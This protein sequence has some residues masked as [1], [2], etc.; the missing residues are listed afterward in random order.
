MR[1]SQRVAFLGLGLMGAPMARRLLDA[2][3]ELV[4]WNRS[5]EKCDAL[6][7]VG[8]RPA[9]TPAQA[10]A[11]A[12]FVCT[13]LLDTDTMERVTFGPGGIAAGIESGACLID[14]STISPEWVKRAH[15]R[16][17]A[18]TGAEWIDAPVSGGVSGAAAGTL[19]VFCGG[20][21]EEVEAA[22]P[23]L[24]SLAARV[25][26]FGPVGSGLVAKLCNQTIVASQLVA[27][28]EALGLAAR[29]G[30]DPRA[31]VDAL[32]GGFADSTLLRQFGPRFAT[33]CFEPRTGQI[34]TMLDTLEMARDLGAAVGEPM[35]LSKAAA[36]VY[37]AVGDGGALSSDLTAL[38][39][40]Y[41]TR[42]E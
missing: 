25:T 28:A 23:L 5:P 7:A 17:R 33:G 24:A 26:R 21:A 19:V 16:L 20:R 41:T 35:P 30:L 22:R 9:S 36:A 12:R 10:A 8:A 14:F 15:V 40:F 18:E 11:G 13:C 3:H 32:L 39:N 34:Y 6:V 29:A 1:E 38:M 37:R 42:A 31:L 27:I 2:G 4:V